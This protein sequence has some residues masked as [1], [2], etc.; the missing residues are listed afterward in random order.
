MVTDNA[1]RRRLWKWLPC[2]FAGAIFAYLLSLG[3]VF[4][5]QRHGILPQLG[6]M[7]DLY[8]YPANWMAH[9][10]PVHKLME[11][12]IALWLNVT[13]APDITT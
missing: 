7:I 6:P 1:K 10:R 4:A 5:M 12:Y 8:Q 11:R 3:P 13:D 9:I 2:F